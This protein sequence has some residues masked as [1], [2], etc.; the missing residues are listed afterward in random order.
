MS[1][2]FNSQKFPWFAAPAYAKYKLQISLTLINYKHATLCGSSEISLKS[3]DLKTTAPYNWVKS[4]SNIFLLLF[5]AFLNILM[6]HFEIVIAATFAKISRSN[7]LMQN[8][9]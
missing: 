5:S 4:L 3:D 8:S 9:E 6:Q 1:K 2:L 7:G